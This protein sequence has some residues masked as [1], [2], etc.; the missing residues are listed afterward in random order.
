MFDERTTPLFT[1]EFDETD[2]LSQLVSRL[3]DVCKTNSTQTVLFR[4]D[5]LKTIVQRA[6]SWYVDKRNIKNVRTEDVI[7]RLIQ[8]SLGHLSDDGLILVKPSVTLMMSDC[9]KNL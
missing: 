1:L 5:Q 8:L 9:F 6:S 2:P 4:P 3:F 7:N